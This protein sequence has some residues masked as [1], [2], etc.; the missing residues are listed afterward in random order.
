MLF[1]SSRLS[2]N[3]EL[4]ESITL[5]RFP[6]HFCAVTGNVN[7]AAFLYFRQFQYSEGITIANF[8]AG[9]AI[10]GNVGNVLVIRLCKD[11]PHSVSVRKIEQHIA[12]LDEELHVHEKCIAADGK[13]GTTPWS[14]A[15]TLSPVE[16]ANMA[17]KPCHLI[18][19]YFFSS[20]FMGFTHL[21]L[22]GHGHAAVVLSL[23]LAQVPLHWSRETHCLFPECFKQHVSVPSYKFTVM[24][25]A[26]VV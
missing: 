5:E 3:P 9:K 15:V 8:A 17:G 12:Q 13:E 20:Y 14:K 1:T 4:T 23:I 19:H 24:L 11:R 7:L 16:I 22:A 2:L 18:L 21:V 10:Q 25:P 26:K 6:Y